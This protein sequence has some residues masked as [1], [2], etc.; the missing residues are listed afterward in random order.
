MSVVAFLLEKETIMTDIVLKNI[1]NPKV[2]LDV[3]LSLF[4]NVTL[5]RNFLLEPGS[6]AYECRACN[7]SDQILQCEYC[8]HKHDP[9]RN[10]LKPIVRDFGG[11]GLLSV[12]NAIATLPS[13]TFETFMD[14]LKEVR[15]LALKEAEETSHDPTS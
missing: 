5:N 9:N 8:H 4:N 11:K 15:P 14:I 1:E 7:H 10:P 2:H 12:F 13:P 3:L 6:I